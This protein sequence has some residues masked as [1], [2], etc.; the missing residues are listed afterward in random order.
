[1]IKPRNGSCR[2]TAAIFY[3]NRETKELQENVG[4]TIC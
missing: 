2:S 1:M 3:E 4:K